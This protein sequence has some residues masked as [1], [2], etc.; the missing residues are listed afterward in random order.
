MPRN[1]EP[2]PQPSREQLRLICA[3]LNERRLITTELYVDGPHYLEIDELHVEVL[4]RGDADLQAVQTA[5]RDAIETYLHPIRG[6]DVSP[7]T[8][9]T[10][11]GAEPEPT[12]W[13]IGGDIYVGNVFDRLLA[14]EGV[15]RV[16]E[17]R[18]GTTAQPADG[19]LDVLEVPPG[20]LVHLPA[21]VL[22]IEVSYDRGR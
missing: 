21:G 16:A 8:P 6:G 11:D 5:C 15:A 4:A 2:T 14:Q 13:P 17:L 19:C 20:T 7:P 3:F 1:A 9:E 22:S 18:I 12:G 10:D